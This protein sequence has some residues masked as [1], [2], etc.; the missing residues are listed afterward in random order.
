M[1]RTIRPARVS[2]A[3]AVALWAFFGSAALAEDATLERD[4]RGKSLLLI[5]PSRTPSGFLHEWPYAL[6]EPQP[7][8][9]WSYRLSTE[10]GALA[11]RGDANRSYGDFRDGATISYLAV[12]LDRPGSGDYVDFAGAAFGRDDQRYAAS[13]GRYGDFAARLHFNRSPK[14]FTDQARTLFHGAGTGSL[15]LPA[16]LTPGTSS[17]A[18]IAAALAAAPRLS[19][20][21]GRKNAGAQ[22]EATPDGRWRLFA[23]YELDRK[24]GTRPSGGASGYPGA[25]LV[26][27][28][29]P[30]DYRTHNVL[31]GAQWSGEALQVNA[32]YTA[33][34]F[35][36]GIDTLTW[37]SPFTPGTNRSDLYPDNNAHS[38]KL[39]LAA[40][41]PLRGRLTGGVSLTRMKQDDAL[42]APT[43]DIPDWDTPAALGQQSAGARID[44]RLLHLGG[45]FSPVRDLTLHAKL[46][47]YDEDNKTRY[48]AF[49]PLTGQFGYIGLDGG[50]NNVVPAFLRVQI[51]NVP[52]EQ[53]KDNYSAEADYRAARHTNLTL[54]YE[55]E[56][57]ERPYREAKKTAE[58][59]WRIAASNRDIAWATL[60]L[61]YEHAQ[62]SATEYDF[63][64]N[65]AS[66]APGLAKAPATL[67]ELRKHDLAERRQQ[68][69]N[70]RI[71]FL[72]ASDMDLALSTRLV[73]NDYG[74]EYGRLGERIAALNLEWS[75]QPGP[76]SSAHAHYGFERIRNRM[77]LISDD[78]GGYS[79]GDPHAGGAVYPLANQWDETSCEDAH[80]LGLGFRQALGPATLE[81]G[82]TY[83]YSPYRTQYSFAGAGDSMPVIAF[84]EHT[85]ETSL[86]F[87]LDRD[88]ALRLYHRYQRARFSDWHYDGLPLLFGNGEALFLGAG[89]QDY[90]AHV[91]GVFFQYVPGR[92]EAP[93]R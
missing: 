32:A 33:S 27:T 92:R 67:A 55:R 26:E 39:D 28:I 59:R 75:W 15:T 20:G 42:V 47:H 90:S 30:I 19:L 82:Y 25:P 11:T 53:H 17:P 88:T 91:I 6:P 34:F 56:S 12:G 9:D 69:L 43:V 48:S 5:E 78:P 60:R 41:L 85:L 50:V 87:R 29:E 18:E 14:E 66:Y 61:S 51:R 40:A 86:K 76:R 72:V 80:L 1:A 10:L 2:T 77:A 89:P 73:D 93:A 84:R 7:L 65:G 81:S 46:R 83:V 37:E 68:I 16:S 71:N 57:I 54:G 45:S 52:F 21:F 79:T 4:A 8:G 22:F 70:G 31:A 36:N 35:R 44:T 58:D 3:S 13:F 38:V 49:N 23:G 63:D 64:P 24:N 62:R 74:A